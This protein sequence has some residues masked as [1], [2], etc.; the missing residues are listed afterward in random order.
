MY[1]EYALGLSERRIYPAFR[2]Q[3]ERLHV[4]HVVMPELVALIT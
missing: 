1:D 4:Q 2:V 3:T